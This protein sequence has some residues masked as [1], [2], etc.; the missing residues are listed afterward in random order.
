M[1]EFTGRAESVGTQVARVA[2]GAA[3][4]RWIAG[5]AREVETA[6]VLAAAELLARAPELAT[7]LSATGI[8]VAVPGGP[9]DAR[10]A[11][12]GLSFGRMAVAEMGSVL[13]AEPTL[14]DRSIGLLCRAQVVVVPTNGLV[15]SMDDAAPALREIAL[16]SGGGMAT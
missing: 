7:T 6:R 14:G 11:P 3:A 16:E 8:A 15:A 9:D 1:K 13:L 12:L 2:D 4:A 10:D 5:I